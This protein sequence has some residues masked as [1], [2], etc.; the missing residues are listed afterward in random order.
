MQKMSLSSVDANMQH[1]Y[2][3]SLGSK[4]AIISVCLEVL[5]VH[6]RTMAT[7]QAGVTLSGQY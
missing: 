7:I 2:R 4:Q 1:T 5:G 6:V 3:V